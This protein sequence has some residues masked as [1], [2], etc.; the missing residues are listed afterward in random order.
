MR[1]SGFNIYVTGHPEPGQTLVYNTFSGGFVNLDDATLAVLRRADKGADLSEEDRG[2]ID[3]DFFDDSV[4]I[5]V[6][7]RKAEELEFRQWHER[8]RSQT[9]KLSCIVSTTFACNFDCT[10]CCQSDVLDGRT[11]KADLGLHTAAW[12]AGRAIEIGATEIHLDFVGGEPL[13]H[14][15]RIE[16]IVGDIRSM[17]AGRGINLVF[18]LITNGLFL[19]RDLVEKWQPIGLRW[20]QVTLDGD[21]TTHSITRRSKKK[22]EDSFATIFANVVAASSLIDIK[23][24]GNYQTDTVHGFVPLLEKLRAAGLKSGSKVSFTPALAGLG[25]P[26]DAASGSCLWSGSNP[27]L[28]IAL[29]DEVRRN[30]FDTG[31]LVSI[32][33]CSFHQKQ[34]FAIDPEGH[35]YKCPG[36]LGKPEWAIGHITSGLTSRYDGLASTNPQRLCGSCAHRP[37]CA[38]GC[39]ATEWLSRGRSEGVNCEITFFEKHRDELIKRKYA[40][41]VTETTEEALALFPAPKTDIPR[42]PVRRSLKLNVIQAA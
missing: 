31:D 9:A 12:L 29:G 5:V 24:N 19:T 33:P 1:L 13:L 7:S 8:T 40:L 28:M 25:A 20:A 32:G 22:G 4:G 30:G 21:E 39:V 10:Y 17:V 36:F 11:M 41:A 34:S 35:I 3:P 38:G 26:S 2:L 18:G 37:D 42:A 23:L 14:P 16:Q 6:E 15:N 27:E